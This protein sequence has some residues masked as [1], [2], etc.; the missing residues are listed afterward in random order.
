MKRVLQ[1]FGLA[2]LCGSL[3]YV[4]GAFLF[5]GVPLVGAPFALAA[6]GLITVG[7][8]HFAR[9]IWRLLTGKK[10]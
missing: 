10:M 1:Y 4:F 8:W 6:F 3:G 9:W 7:W 5:P 2:I